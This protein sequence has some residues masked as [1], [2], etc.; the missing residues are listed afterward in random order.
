MSNKIKT[1]KTINFSETFSSAFSVGLNFGKKIAFLALVLGVFA[2]PSVAFLPAEALVEA[3][4]QE[5]V[6]E[7]G[8]AQS[9]VTVENT[10]N[11]SEVA[12]ESGETSPPTDLEAELPSGS[13]ASSEGEPS[14]ADISVENTSSAEVAT[15]ATSTTATGENNANENPGSATIETGDANSSA[16]VINVV[17]STFTDSNGLVLL[18]NVFS[19]LLGDLDFSN[20]NFFNSSCSDNCSIFSG[21]LSVQN[22]NAATVTNDVV[23]RAQTGGNFAS[24]NAGDGT[25]LTGDANAAANVLNIVNTNVVGSNYLLLVL[26]NFG[27]WSGDL[28]LPSKYLFSQCCAEGGVNTSASNQNSA[29]IENNISSEAETGS[30]EANENANGLVVTGTANAVNNTFNQANTNIFGSDSV[31]IAFRFFG[32]WGGN[33]FSAPDGFTWTE[34]NGGL[35]ILGNG[36]GSSS[37]SSGS[38]ASPAGGSSGSNNST[39]I[40]NSNQA[41]IRNNIRVLALTGANKATGNGGTS[42]IATGNAN[43][44]TN[45]VNVVNTNIFGRNWILAII[46]VFGNWHG[47]IAFGRPDLWVGESVS[48]IPREAMPGDKFTY[49]L[50]VVNNGDTDATNILLHDDFDERYLSPTSLNGGNRTD[51]GVEWNLGMLRPGEARVIS[52]EVSIRDN[53]PAGATFLANTAQVSSFEEDGKSEDNSERTNIL[54]N[55][56]REPNISNSALPDFRISKING[57]TSGTARPGES[58]GY[59]IILK[60]VGGGKGYESKVVDK[61]Y[62]ATGTE[63]VSVREWPLDIVLDGEEITITYTL[64]FAPNAKP[65]IYKNVAK[66]SA[67]DESGVDRYFVSAEDSIEILPVEPLPAPETT[68]EIN[69]VTPEPASV[70]REIKKTVSLITDYI[71]KISTPEPTTIEDLEVAEEPSAPLEESPRTSR[72]MNLMSLAFLNFK[73][74]WQWFATTAAGILAVLFIKFYG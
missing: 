68:P 55:R 45:V 2:L 60:N 61:L 39:N 32:D 27:S 52:Y 15:E 20:S 1:M 5:V 16:N 73:W 6:I 18:L 58:V 69:A 43:A 29:S 33:V 3:G 49:T 23:A 25:I 57:A 26:N 71:P 9:D 36:Q 62:Y 66:F 44:A 46:N 12:V 50:T 67:K 48:S 70:E 74:I 65:G 40:E 42:T 56:K 37:Q 7:T 72:F 13:S 47:N 22:E 8:N 4:A 41:A 19:S 21:D 10:A 35:V 63:P 38:P 34:S 14:Q 64:Q 30:N 17:N 28:V 53:L 51:R 31:M 59:K 24:G 54:I 11:T